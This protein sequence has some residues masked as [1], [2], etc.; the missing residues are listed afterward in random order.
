MS[1]VIGGRIRVRAD[2]DP[3]IRILQI[4]TVETPD[5]TRVTSCSLSSG[6]ECKPIDEDHWRVLGSEEVL[7]R[8]DLP[9]A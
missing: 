5:G 1:V 2:G 8:V 9:A 6:Q 7:H 3:T 4:A